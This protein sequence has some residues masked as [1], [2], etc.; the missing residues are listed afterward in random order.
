[1]TRFFYCLLA[2]VFSLSAAA[3]DLKTAQSYFDKREES[4]DHIHEAQRIYLKII[5]DKKEKLE[6]RNL[7]LSM[8]ARLAIFEGEV[9][10]EFH[11]VTNKESEKIF[12]ACIDATEY[13]DPDKV[14]VQ[15]AEYTYYR[16]VCIGLW[17][18]HIKK[19]KLVVAG[20]KRMMEIKKLV[21]YGQAHFK[22][23][24]N[25]GFDRIE[26]GIYVHDE[27]LAKFGLWDPPRSLR[28]VDEA[29][30]NGQEIHV[31]CLLKA[32]VLLVMDRKDEAIESIK[33]GI[34]SLQTRMKNPS[35]QSIESRLFL[36]TLNAELTRL[37]K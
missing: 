8:Y 7:A 35:E 33:I 5:K 27:S 29:I 11:G 14:G 3:S 2:I 34:T 23:Y 25:Y 20:L 10:T 21:A 17:G 32:Q 26:A 36:Q 19:A 18:N 22:E 6:N 30:K 9:A 16:L 1:M 37:T 28:L 15:T 31:S 24:D 4:R 13:L 12:D